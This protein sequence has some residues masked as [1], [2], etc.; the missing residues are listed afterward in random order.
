MKAFDRV[1]D[2]L[3]PATSILTTPAACAGDV[4]VTVVAVFPPTVAETPSKVTWSMKARFVPVSTTDV[5]PFVPPVAGATLV[6]V[7]DAANVN[8]DVF[9]TAPPAVV[10]TTF[11]T[12][13]A[14]AGVV[15]TTDVADTD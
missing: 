13:A 7:G 12:P 11:T 5:D 3:G 10:T 14:L 4:T 9:V 2:P 15:T 8:A 1:A 6:T